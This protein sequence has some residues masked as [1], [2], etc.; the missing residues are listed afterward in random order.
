MPLELSIYLC[1]GVLLML[2]VL[3]LDW[4]CCDQITG[5]TVGM[6][7]LTLFL[8]PLVLVVLIAI[9][10]VDLLDSNFVIARRKK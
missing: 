6:G 8:W 1:V 3:M 10:I 4:F 7:L 2:A 5:D 9:S